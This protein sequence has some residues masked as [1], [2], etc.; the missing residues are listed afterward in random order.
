[1]WELATKPL[2]EKQLGSSIEDFPKKN[3]NKRIILV[4][5]E[6]VILFTYKIF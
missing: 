2:F 3:D 1:M 5:D 6:Q 4:D